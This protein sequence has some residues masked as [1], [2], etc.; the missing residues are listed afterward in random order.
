MYFSY[1][2]ETLEVHKGLQ[3][4]RDIQNKSLVLTITHPRRSVH[5][6][7]VEH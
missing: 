5:E 2:Y 7:P 4:V 6:G 3:N 1:I